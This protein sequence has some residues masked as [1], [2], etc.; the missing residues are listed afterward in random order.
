MNIHSIFDWYCYFAFFT[1]VGI[2]LVGVDMH[3]RATSKPHF[4]TVQE[5]RL[6]PKTEER[7]HIATSTFNTLTGGSLTSLLYNLENVK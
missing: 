5:M 1:A 3:E 7:R 4:A 2:V 6:A